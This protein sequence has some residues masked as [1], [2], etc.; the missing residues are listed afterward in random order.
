MDAQIF[1]QSEL[2]I[3]TGVPL[4]PTLN[5]QLY[6]S[7]YSARDS[8]FNSKIF[9]HWNDFKYLREDNNVQV[10]GIETEYY[11]VN[12]MRFKNNETGGLWIYAFI[13]GTE[14]VNN[15]TTKLSFKVDAWQTYFNFLTVKDCDIERMH[16][17]DKNS[18]WRTYTLNEGIDFGDYTIIQ[19]DSVIDSIFLDG[20]L[21]MSTIDLITSG[22]DINNPIIKTARGGVYMGSASA[23]SL[24]YTPDIASVMEGLLEYPWVA[25]GIIGIYPIS[26]DMIQGGYV[27]N[28]SSMGFSIGSITKGTF[29]TLKN[30]EIPLN[31]P[32]VKNKK[33]YTYPYTYISISAPD[34]NNIILKP[35]LLN[36][37]SVNGCVMYSLIPTPTIHLYINKYMGISSADRF[38]VSL[39]FNQFPSFPCINDQ[40]TLAKE[41]SRG[42]D[43]LIAK[44]AQEEI[45]AQWFG[46]VGSAIGGGLSSGGSG[47]LGGAIE[48]S[49][50]TYNSYNQEQR[51]AEKARLSTNQIATAPQLSGTSNA[52]AC[53]PVFGFDRT[54][55]MRMNVYSVIPAMRNNIDKYFSVYG[56]KINQIKTPNLS[57]ENLRY[58]YIKCNHVNMFGD[59]PQYYLEQ[60]RGMFLD[61]VTLWYDVNNVGVYE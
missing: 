20:A 37:D 8:F 24:Y 51:R 3:L 2:D 17:S 53:A 52:G 33:L 59:I 54:I 15:H 1:Y 22:G 25:S 47:F 28:Q 40:Y 18:A 43:N 11:N 6:F 49:I 46:A 41:Q 55:A 42:M 36:G 31:L 4:T 61:G 13:L 32:S 16:V 48:G 39:T 57:A 30:F 60:I 34:G 21:I 9:K 45:K 38:T 26:T 7:S 5:H 27:M 14:Y 29:P 35:E 10:P 44:Q 58:K 50:K 19:N 12:Y 56:Y 23:C